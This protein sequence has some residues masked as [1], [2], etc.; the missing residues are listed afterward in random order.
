MFHELW[1]GLELN[2]TFKHQ[3]WGKVQKYLLL[4]MLK[5]LKP[6]LIHT[7][8]EWYLYNLTECGFNTGKL[9][10]F[11]NIK[12][13]ENFVRLSKFESIY[14][15]TK[16]TITFLVFGNINPESPITDFLY[17]LKQLA[18][19]FGKTINLKMIGRNYSEQEVW[20]D[21]WSKMGFNV[22]VLGFREQSEISK[23][24]SESDIGIATTPFNVLEKS[25]SFMS[26]L[27][28]GLPVL[29]VAKAKLI[30]L[31]LKQTDFIGLYVYNK[32]NL[33][34]ILTQITPPAIGDQSS[35][36]ADQLIKKYSEFPLKKR[37]KVDDKK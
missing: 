11:S 9:K 24:M 26:M 36:V 35:I 16:S 2:P 1:L 29:N 21:L 25:G 7:N 33:K 12:V 27:E 37:N 8:T 20:I 15:K 5:K 19:E 4:N 14:D 6:D 23:E 31:E 34:E 17:E 10:L 22:D 30:P 18:N 28:H 13:P 3:I 32:G